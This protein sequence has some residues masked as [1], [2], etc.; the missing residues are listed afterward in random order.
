MFL[1]RSAFWLG[2]ALI[3][4]Q[5]QGW[6]LG[7][8]SNAQAAISDVSQQALEGAKL[9][10]TSCKIIQCS[11]DKALAIVSG[12]ELNPS[13]ASPIQDSSSLTLAPVPRPRLNRAG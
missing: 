8:T 7:G 10:K 5:S 3:V 9:I 11:G 1:L 4:T 12:L 6:A 13:Q 2:L